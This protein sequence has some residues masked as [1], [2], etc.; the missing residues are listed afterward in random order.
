MAT[1]NRA[2]IL[3]YADLMRTDRVLETAVN[4]FVV[5]KPQAYEI[6]GGFLA[7]ETVPGTGRR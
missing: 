3:P 1:N 7:W 6:P 2:D 5:A 4:P